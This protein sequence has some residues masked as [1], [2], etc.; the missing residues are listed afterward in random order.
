MKKAKLVKKTNKKTQ[1]EQIPE[2]NLSMKRI[3]ITFACI[4]L[5]FVAFYFLTDFLLSKRVSS[6]DSSSNSSSTNTRVIPFS[7]LLTQSAEKYYVIAAIDE[8]T[9]AYERYLSWMS[10]TYY[11][12]DMT[13]KVNEV[14][15][16]EE[17]KIGES[18]KDIRIKETTLFVVED[19]KLQDH[20][21]GKEAI[22]K[23]LEDELDK[24]AAS[25]SNS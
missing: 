14:Y 11:T 15:M 2:N 7:K 20:V 13:N 22:L 24:S 1:K 6:A 25:S 16:G 5:T 21:S 12:I 9:E 23:Y 3:V 19:G 18:V 17:E 4:A 8:K 10:K